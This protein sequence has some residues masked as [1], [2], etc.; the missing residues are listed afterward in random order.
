V[1]RVIRAGLAL[2]C[3]VCLLC[4]SDVLAAESGAASVATVLARAQ[5]R[6]A[7]IDRMQ[8]SFKQVTFNATMGKEEHSRGL[9]YAEKPG[10]VRWDYEKPVVQHLVVSGGRV[11]FYVP[12]DKQLVFSDASEMEELK[13]LLDLL[14]GQRSVMGRFKA[15][16]LPDDKRKPK[17]DRYVVRIVPKKPMGNLLRLDLAINKKTFLV[18]ETTYVDIYGNKTRIS[19][20]HIK[21]PKRFKSSLFALD[22]PQNVTVIDSAGNPVRRGAAQK[23]ATKNKPADNVQGAR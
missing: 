12:S 16:L 15:R 11:L 21:M 6:Y 10:K 9:Y 3:G 20:S 17:S 1:E 7:A 23:G 14:G 18:E 13:A 19:F 8:A 2:A 5:A 22:V 4:V